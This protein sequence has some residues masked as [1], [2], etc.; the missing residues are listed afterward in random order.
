MKRR[1]RTTKE[2]YVAGAENRK[3][4]P[5]EIARQRMLLAQIKIDSNHARQYAVTRC[6]LKTGRTENIK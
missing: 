5:V 1:Y 6:D 3:Q 4:V 2:N